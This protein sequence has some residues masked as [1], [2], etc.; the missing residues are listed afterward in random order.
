MSALEGSAKVI[1][2]RVMV[3]KEDQTMLLSQV[4]S[5][6]LDLFQETNSGAKGRQKSV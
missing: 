1:P 5:T 2:R 6:R 3:S 4:F